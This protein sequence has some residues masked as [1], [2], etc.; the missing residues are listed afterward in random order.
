VAHL[1]NTTSLEFR[2][3]SLCL[4]YIPKA[5]SGFVAKIRLKIPTAKLGYKGENLKQEGSISGIMRPEFGIRYYFILLIICSL[6]YI[7]W[8]SKDKNNVQT[9]LI[10]IGEED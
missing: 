9:V 8:E 10:A 5:P 2:S 6:Y 7:V 4:R 1:G 3:L